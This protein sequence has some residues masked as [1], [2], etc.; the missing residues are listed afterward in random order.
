MWSFNWY[1][2]GHVCWHVYSR[3]CIG[4]ERISCCMYIF[5]IK[6]VW[7]CASFEASTWMIQT[8]N[9]C[10]SCFFKTI[11]LWWPPSPLPSPSAIGI[12]ELSKDGTIYLLVYFLDIYFGWCL[13]SKRYFYLSTASSKSNN[14][15]LQI[16]RIQTKLPHRWWSEN[17]KILRMMLHKYSF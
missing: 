2:I 8:I 9:E 13:D 3:R 1:V 10:Y 17:T 5:T 6:K 7:V 12:G 4:V 11:N 14:N 15:R 16:S